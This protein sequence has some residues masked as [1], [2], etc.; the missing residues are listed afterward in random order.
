[1]AQH[2]PSWIC[3]ITFACWNLFNLRPKGEK[4]AFELTPIFL[5]NVVFVPR[6]GIGEQTGA[7]YITLN[8]HLLH[9]I[10]KGGLVFFP[11]FLSCGSF[12]WVR[13]CSMNLRKFLIPRMCW[14]GFMW[15][16]VW[17]TLNQALTVMFMQSR[18]ETLGLR[19]NL[20]WF[21]L[22]E[23]SVANAGANPNPRV[24]GNF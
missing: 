21:W 18:P 7:T 9:F 6:G 22:S 5:K 8:T 20:Y 4:Q 23:I 12:L 15:T 14:F 1:M 3:G 17:Q 16:A 24:S 11:P 10:P 13:E 2:C 19:M